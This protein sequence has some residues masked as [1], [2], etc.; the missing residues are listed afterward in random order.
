MWPPGD[1]ERQREAWGR[2]AMA[3]CRLKKRP[4]AAMLAKALVPYLHSEEGYAWVSDAVLAKDMGCRH[5]SAVRRAVA[6]AANELGIITRDTTVV[7]GSNGRVTGRNRR[8]YPCRP[9]N[10]ADVLRSRRAPNAESERILTAKPKAS[11]SFSVRSIDAETTERRTL[12]NRTLN[13]TPSGSAKIQDTD[14]LSRKNTE[15][16]VLG[17]SGFGG[18][19]G[20]F[21]D[22]LSRIGPNDRSTE[23]EVAALLLVGRRAYSSIKTGQLA[24]AD[25]RTVITCLTDAARR[26][27]I[28]HRAEAVTMFA[29]LSQVCPEAA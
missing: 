25:A 3:Y 24:G 11:P 20:L 19:V 23:D 8:I 6:L 21:I 18:E 28:D 10:M 16:N 13:R 1:P 7:S 9:D 5:D 15:L 14:S 17:N 29:H 27:W 4:T 26:A 2:D 22:D 12:N